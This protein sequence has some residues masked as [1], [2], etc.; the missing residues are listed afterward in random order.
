[1][2]ALVLSL[3]SLAGLLLGLNA[4]AHRGVYL[5]I[6]G[7]VVGVGACVIGITALTK[8]RR[9]TSFR[10]HGA[11]GGIV[12]GA[13]AAALALSTLVMYLAFS[14]QFNRY[15]TCTSH[16]QTTRQTQ[17]CY[18]KFRRSVMNAVIGTGNGQSAVRSGQG[19]AAGSPDGHGVASPESSAHLSR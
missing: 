13:L 3:L 9:T 5:L 18:D 12:L 10:P 11:V 7:A 17:A 15:F 1:M 2:A 19:S 14:S 6:F 8:A 16:A 4:L